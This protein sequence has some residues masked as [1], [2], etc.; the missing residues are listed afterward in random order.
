MFPFYNSWKHQKAFGFLVFSGGYK[1]E[2]L[3]WNGLTEL[4]SIAPEIIGKQ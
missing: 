2:A 4:T 3:A 1:M